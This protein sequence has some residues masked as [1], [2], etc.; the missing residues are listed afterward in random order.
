[1]GQAQVSWEVGWLWECVGGVG[2]ISQGMFFPGRARGNRVVPTLG[3]NLCFCCCLS[4][5]LA[6][7]PRAG[8]WRLVGIAC[9]SL[10]LPRLDGL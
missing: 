9:G 10:C 3:G 8:A 7:A 2:K 1:M 4:A 6:A 5:A